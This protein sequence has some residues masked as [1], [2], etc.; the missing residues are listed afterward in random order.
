MRAPSDTAWDGKLMHLT[1]PDSGGRGWW[2]RCH[3]PVVFASLQYT[4][5][6][7]PTCLWCIAGLIYP[8]DRRDE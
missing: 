7:V 6:A 8:R 4:E 5:T 1:N 2:V 3:M